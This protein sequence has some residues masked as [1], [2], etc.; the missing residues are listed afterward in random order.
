MAT[1]EFSIRFEAAGAEALNKRI[2]QATKAFEDFEKKA[3]AVARKITDS[4]KTVVREQKQQA[5]AE[6][7]DARRQ[8]EL[9]SDT[10]KKRLAKLEER[11]QRE[12]ARAES[13][14]ENLELVEQVH[15]QR[16]AALQER[17]AKEAEQIHLRNLQNR[18]RAIEDA[19]DRELALLD[20]KHERE[21]AAA[22][23]QGADLEA[24]A[25]A[26]ARE[27]ADLVAKVEEAA[28]DS[29]AAV[30]DAVE[31]V[32]EQVDGFG[33]ALGGGVEALDELGEGAGR[34]TGLVGGLEDV[35]KVAS[36]VFILEFVQSVIEGVAL[37][38]EAWDKW[39]GK[40]DQIE[41]DARKREQ[42]LDRLSRA[43]D[44]YKQ[45][46]DN[47]AAAEE[48]AFGVQ[49]FLGP[50]ERRELLK[51]EQGIRAKQRQLDQTLADLD[52]GGVR[53][54]GTRAFAFR[55]KLIKQTRVNAHGSSEL[56]EGA[57]FDARAADLDKLREQLSFDLIGLNLRR[58]KLLA[59]A[60]KRAAA[61]GL[62]SDAPGGG[63]SG[64]GGG[65]A[66]PTTD[67]DL[68][69]V[70]QGIVTALTTPL[71]VA[72]AAV[73]TAFED[74]FDAYVEQITRPDG[75]GA[76]V[77]AGLLQDD[78]MQQ[79]RERDRSADLLEGEDGVDPELAEQ[80]RLAAE[81]I[82]LEEH[83]MAEFE[84]AREHGDD[85]VKLEALHQ[86]QRLAI[87]E[88]FAAKRKAAQLAEA[89]AVIGY[90]KAFISTGKQ[91]AEKA[92]AS[93]AAL[94]VISRLEQLA[95][96]A[97][98]I[99]DAVGGNPIGAIKAAAHIFAAAQF[100]KVASAG[101]KGGGGG[102]VPALSTSTS[103]PGSGDLPGRGGN[104][105]GSVNLTM[106]VDGTLLDEDG[107]SSAI[108]RAQA[109]AGGQPA[110]GIGGL[111]LGRTS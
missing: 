14:G 9:I 43:A 11:Y 63:G 69:P 36:G 75:G 15:L 52:T 83:Q 64:S 16:V 59:D 7:A 87:Q 106:R 21:I 89:K 77:A 109:I 17:A 81:L 82:R 61:E 48:Q 46:L 37:I 78:R 6:Q 34:V 88:K 5:Q 31:G 76:E 51:I 80:E 99:A 40:T 53:G 67:A 84:L 41:N 25:E 8:I 50:A 39:S 102:S 97:Q 57:T 94:A 28:A 58:Q 71:D 98:G 85:L 95:L 73:V 30:G 66:A 32:A 45:A 19:N 103:T 79:A 90:S 62:G 74:G 47:V 1:S 3:S 42:V 93:K 33:D 55:N 24:L 2:A 4:G 49:G 22:R 108:V 104:G 65:A 54:F 72:V 105:G 70:A 111:Q 91:I 92:G 18:A 38:N 12:K 29:T 10:T 96:A 23:R 44:D 101:G 68:S 27:R 100:G 56:Q 86:K 26:Q 35:F 13:R 110:V 20:V 60:R 107:L